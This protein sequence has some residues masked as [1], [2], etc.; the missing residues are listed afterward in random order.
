MP[1][2]ASALPVRQRQGLVGALAGM[3]LIVAAAAAH[4]LFGVGGSGLDVPV[5][6]W[7]SSAVYV[8]AALIVVMRAVMVKKSRTAWIAIAVGTCLYGAGNLVWAFWLQQLP[9]PPIPSIS[10]A[11]WLSLYPASYLGI[12]LLARRQWRGL[13]AGVWLDGIV[14]GLGITA[15]GATVVFEP[16]L[17]SLTGDR[18]VAAVGLAYPACDL[19]LAALVVGA[20]AL[21]GWRL[22]RSWALLGTGFLTLTVADSIYLLHVAHGATDASGIANIFYLSAVA[23]IAFAAWQQPER[24]QLPQTDG[25]T[26]LVMPVAFALVGLTVL[27][28]DQFAQLANL[29]VALAMLTVIAALLR[30]LLAFRDLRSFNEARRQAV[31]DDLTELPN[32]R[33]FQRR[34]EEAID[35]GAAAGVGMAVLIV[36]L[37]HFKELNDTLGHHSGDELLRQIGPRLSGLIRPVDT[38]ARLGGDEF[39]VVIDAPADE[40]EALAVADRIAAALGRPFQVQDLALRVDASVGIALYPAHA[41]SAGELLRRADVALYQAKETRSG[42]ALYAPD[43]DKHSRDRLALAAELERAIGNGEIELYFQPKADSRTRQVV[44]AE[45]LVRWQHPVHGLLLPQDFIPLAETTGLIRALTRLVLD[46]ALA[47]CDTWR[48]AGFELSVSVNASVADLLDVDLP[49]QIAA[50]LDTH[51]LPAAALVIEVTESSILT[52]PVR[53]HGV[54]TRL[55]QLGVLLSLDDFGTGFSSLGHLKSLPVDEIKIDR[56]FVDHMTTNRADSAIVHATIELAHRLGKRVVA[57]GVEDEPT[58]KLLMA[59]GCNQI[60]GYAL[61]RPLPPAQLEPLLAE[62][63]VSRHGRRGLQRSLNSAKA[64]TS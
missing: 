43:R 39:G 1:S 41:D 46:R 42:R 34:L 38:L 35:H 26:T 28:Y 5:R 60:Q 57:E 24:S 58:W 23:L 47:Q 59:A 56:S 36:D 2:L 52:D 27:G 63:A 4:T 11:M 12:V 53:I 19:L 9:N 16:V 14:A 21:R 44:G 29:P 10:D 3:V 62:F 40:S 15:V 61:S 55:E 37:D 48:R 20:L 22:D 6:D 25:V 51:N 32:R 54:L 45:A 33:L 8:L 7:A 18:S 64:A 50:A 13:P 31:T 49:L 17:R 30:F